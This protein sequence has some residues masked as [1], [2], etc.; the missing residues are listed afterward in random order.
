MIF[1]AT[2][3]NSQGASISA[4]VFFS[5]SNTAVVTIA[6]N[7]VVCAGTWD[8]L[9]N[10]TRCTP[11]PVGSAQITATSQGVSSQP[12]TVYVHQH[13][14][15]ITVSPA[16]GQ[17]Q[18]SCVSKGQTFN[19]QARAFSQGSDIT[20]TVGPFSWQAATNASVVTFNTGALPVN[21]VQATANIPGTA[22][23]SASAGPTNSVPVN[24]ITCPVQSIV[25][26]VTSS[27]AT[28]KTIT[29]TVT[30][31]Q[32][33]VITG[34]PLSWCS[35]QPALVSV[36]GSNCVLSPGPVTASAS[37]PGAAAAI[38]ASCTPDACNIG[39]RPTLPIYPENVITLIT[40]GTG[41]PQAS[42][43]Y[44][45]STG[46]GTTVA[47]IS[48]VVPIS[49][50][51]NTVGLAAGLPATPNSLVFN[52]EGTKAYL[53]TD[54]GEL[55][56]KGLTVLTPGNPPGISEFASAPGKVLA[57]SPDGNT[58]ITSDI[59]DTPNQVFIFNTTTNSATA[60]RI[61]GATAADFS[62]DNLKAF[63]V[64][65]S[66]L[67]VYSRLD[68]LRTIPLA[69]VARDVSFLSEGA[70]GYLAGGT[71]Q[72]VAVYRTCDDTQADAVNT[73]GIPSFIKT[74]LDATKVVAVNSP[75]FDI[76]HVDTAPIGCHPTVADSVNAFDLGV[77]NFVAT[78]LI[79]SP[80]GSTAYILTQNLSS[81]LV[82]NIPNLTSTQIPLANNAIPLRAALTPD[83]SL[84]YVGASDYNVHV[85]D[86]ISLHDIQQ[87]PFVQ[88]PT[89]QQGGLCAAVTFS[90]EPDL[91][92]IAP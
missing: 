46:C 23:I 6:A 20:S 66:N 76:I 90:C 68:A 27:T 91:I 58:V 48:T 14:D 85:L 10:P 80:D 43:V 59:V 86:T 49:V 18:V 60:L 13:I 39:F 17:P 38:T 70:F 53:G 83:G 78:Q 26:T 71:P 87:I 62:P 64:A 15:S 24:F 37:V 74:L 50:P 25:L 72:G 56:T 22:P 3:Q 8:S 42:T 61:D 2:P 29:A 89:T 88:N 44:V 51:A 81:V 34:V 79:V 57:I 40:N 65:G 16:P 84:L 28:S 19:Y 52:L 69:A 45:S 67:Y 35:S 82:F 33:I 47:C 54:S 11:G 21:Q 63:I 12:I 77:G 32:N 92:A 73:S 41:V 55:G 31:T 7:G 30:D 9:N 4:P 5:S 1:T 36:G 75:D